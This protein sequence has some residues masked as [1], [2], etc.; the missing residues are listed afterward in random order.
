MRA[1][2]CD[3]AIGFVH[4]Q[5]SLIICLTTANIRISISVVVRGGIRPST[6]LQHLGYHIVRMQRATACLMDVICSIIRRRIGMSVASWHPKPNGMGIWFVKYMIVQDTG[7]LRSIM[8]VFVNC[9]TYRMIV[10]AGMRVKRI[11]TR[12]TGVTVDMS[13]G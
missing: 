12:G 9:V 6:R 10:I 11:A 4:M 13:V 2:D 1:Y 7:I 5:R 3:I 8:I